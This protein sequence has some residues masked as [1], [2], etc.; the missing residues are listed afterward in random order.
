MIEMC[1]VNGIVDFLRYYIS[2][3]RLLNVYFWRIHPKKTR[4]SFSFFVCNVAGVRGKRLSIQVYRLV[5]SEFILYWR[6]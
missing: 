5:T 3:A 4:I 1:S 2:H 6:T